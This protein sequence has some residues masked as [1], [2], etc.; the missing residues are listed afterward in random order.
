M[1]EREKEIEKIEGDKERERERDR[2][3]NL[4]LRVTNIVLGFAA[5]LFR[6]FTKKFE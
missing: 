3:V 4:M 6:L 5:S 1:S 2:L